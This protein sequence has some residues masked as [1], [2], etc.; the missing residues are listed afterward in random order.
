MSA[1]LDFLIT[2]WGGKLADDHIL[3]GFPMFWVARVGKALQIIAGLVVVFDLL[4]AKW[5]T[6]WANRA[7]ARAERR[8]ILIENE[9]ILRRVREDFV[10]VIEPLNRN[11]NSIEFLIRKPPQEVPQGLRL[12]LTAYRDFHRNVVEESQRDHRC[13]GRSDFGGGRRARRQEG[14]PMCSW[15]YWYVLERTKGLVI[16]RLPTNEQAFVGDYYSS[17]VAH[18]L[19]KLF[20][21][22]SI[23]ATFVAIVVAGMPSEWKEKYAPGQAVVS[24][25]MVLSAITY[26]KMT[27]LQSQ[28]DWYRLNRSIADFLIKQAKKSPPFP[29]A[30][31]GALVAF[32]VGA[33]LDL[34]AS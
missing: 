14:P 19:I 2:W 15:E 10:Y 12:T 20:A 32:L 3:W 23:S 1:I 24:V 13:G 30:K 7:F 11:S 17:L 9:I 22:V 4:T 29:A 21:S 6:D 28:L 31:I 8:G 27:S 33:F 34:I 26:S 16:N 5:L 18:K 25:S